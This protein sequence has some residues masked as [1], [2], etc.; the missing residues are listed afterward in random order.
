MPNNINIFGTT[1]ANSTTSS[2]ACYYDDKMETYL[3]DVYSVKWLEDS[4]REN[5]ALETLEQQYQIVKKETST[6]TVCQFGDHSISEM[7]VG[8]FQ[9]NKKST[10][11]SKFN[12]I[13]GVGQKSL[14]ML[15]EIIE[16]FG[17]ESVWS[18]AGCGQNDSVAGPEVPRAILENRLKAA[19]F[20]EEKDEILKELKQLLDNR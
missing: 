13:L 5:L 2:Y 9:G 19:I 18:Y 12:E 8:N 14:M 15:Y 10:Y 11:L 6:S 3:G 17:V 16:N 7:I 4:D 20:P 1:A